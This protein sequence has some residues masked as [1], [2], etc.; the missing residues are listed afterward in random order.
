MAVYFTYRVEILYLLCIRER[1]SMKTTHHPDLSA[2]LEESRS[3]LRDSHR[4][5]LIRM[6]FLVTGSALLVFACLQIFNGYPW[7][8]AGEI[9]ASVLL[10]LGVKQV[11]HTRRLQ[12]W[13]CGYLITLFLFFLLI[14]LVPDASVAAFLWVLLMPVLA[15]LLLGRKAGLRL[16]VPFMVAGCIAYYVYLGSISDARILIDLL[17]MVLA[18]ALMLV[19]IHLYETRREEA[20]QRLVSMAQTDALTGL[21]NRSSF[22]S[23]LNRTVAECQRSG[24]G[25]ALVIMDIDHFKLVNDTMGHGAGDEVLRHIGYQLTERLRSTDSVGRLGGEEFGLILRDVKPADAFDLI[26]EL[27][28]RIASSEVAYGSASIRVT[29]SFGIAQWPEHGQEMETLFHAADRCLYSCKRAGRNT[30]ASPD[31]GILVR[32]ALANS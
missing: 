22:Q 16:S 18:A 20:E 11:G 24:T 26:D 9:A 3:G 19:F 21:S 8:A 14:M 17:N 25:F 31:G 27:R 1:D 29:A 5:S 15:Y 30:V 32:R 13:I 4:R 23:H 6:L 12:V 7:L 10:F 2:S 28:H